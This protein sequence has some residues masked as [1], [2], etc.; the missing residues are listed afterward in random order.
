[1]IDYTVYESYQL[2]VG[3]E[4]FSR[5]IKRNTS[6]QNQN[7]STDEGKVKNLYLEKEK[8]KLIE[9]Y[10]DIFS[11]LIKR[12]LSTKSKYFDFSSFDNYKSRLPELEASFK[13]EFTDSNLLEFY[14]D[15][16]IGYSDKISL[17]LIIGDL[18]N[19][20]NLSIIEYSKLRKLEF[21]DSKILEILNPYDSN[22]SQSKSDEKIEDGKEI[23][24]FNR[25]MKLDIPR[26][27]FKRL[28]TNKSKNGKPFLTET[29]LDNFIQKAF[30]GKDLS[31]Q[32]INIA[33]NG[34]K[35][36]IQS[37][38]Y[39]F[40]DSYSFDY[41]GTQ[42]KQ[43]VFIKLLTDNFDGWIYEKIKGNFKPKTNKRLL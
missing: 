2:E 22:S 31:K 8:H 3:L 1:M 19:R 14:K 17:S 5:L 29:Q 24:I 15:Q 33:P 34:E 13:K 18:I 16:V 9:S 32:K 38:F 35:L 10:N 41:F 27:H 4:E 43:D 39:E 25:K 12:N 20:K 30:L 42:Q 23:N 11:I 40:Y 36:L 21:L 7:F 26:N 6:E 37:V 28:T